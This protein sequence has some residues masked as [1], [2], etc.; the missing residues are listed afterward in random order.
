M[1]VL[2]GVAF[3]LLSFMS[4]GSKSAGT[5]FGYFANMSKF[6]LYPPKLSQFIRVAN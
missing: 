1:T 6:L 4:A 5:V 2:V 3:S